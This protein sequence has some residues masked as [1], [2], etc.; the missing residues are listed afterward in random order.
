M[1]IQIGNHCLTTLLFADD[2]VIVAND[3]EDIDYMLRKLKE[4]YAE[5][6]LKMNMTK[7][8]YLKMADDGQVDR[9]LELSNIK[10]CEEY[11]YLG[12]IISQ[13]GTSNRDIQHRTNTTKAEMYPNSKFS[14]LVE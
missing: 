13:E 11:K 3:E 2:Q 8:E 12:T 14:T 9:S 6:G 1:G 5:W 7:T 10:Q 4:E